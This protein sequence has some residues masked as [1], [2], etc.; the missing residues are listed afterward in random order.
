M[1][2]GLLVVLIYV[3]QGE[4]N[5]TCLLNAFGHLREMSVL[6]TGKFGDTGI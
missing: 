5:T 1:T 4:D 3:F 2:W 6:F